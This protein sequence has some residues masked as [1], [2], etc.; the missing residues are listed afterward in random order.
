[1][2]WAKRSKASSGCA[3]CNISFWQW[4]LLVGFLPI[5]VLLSHCFVIR[6]LNGFNLRKLCRKVNC[7]KDWQ[8]TRN[9]Q[10]K[11][12]NLP[13]TPGC[14]TL[15]NADT[16]NDRDNSLAE[17]QKAAAGIWLYYK[18]TTGS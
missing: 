1:M 11:L 8:P 5:L 16:T 12:G 9:T 10:Q 3:D 14:G 7:P 17:Y 4:N 6:K 18:R 13:T 2:H 15:P